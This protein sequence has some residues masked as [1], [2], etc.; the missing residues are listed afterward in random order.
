MLDAYPA[1]N[2]T[3]EPV[4]YC[5]SP[6]AYTVPTAYAG[7]LWKVGM[8]L[9]MPPVPAPGLDSSASVRQSLDCSGGTSTSVGSSLTVIQGGAAFLSRLGADTATRFKGAWAGG[10]ARAHSEW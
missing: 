1:P 7:S 2:E 4:A 10:V 8:K 3:T 9:A 5:I 6:P